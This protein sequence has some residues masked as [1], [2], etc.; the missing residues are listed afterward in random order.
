M[1]MQP[2]EDP[3]KAAFLQRVRE[4]LG[5]ADPLSATPDY[6]SLKTSLQRHEEKVRTIQAKNAARRPR[7]LTMLAENAT[8]AGWQV[9][10]VE[11]HED[12]AGL[13][14]D[15]A[16]RAGAKKVVRSAEDI[17]RTV[18]LDGALRRKRINWTVLTSG[19]NRQRSQLKDIAFESD[20]GVCGVA[21]AVAETAS[22]A[23][24]PHKG[25]ARL[26]SLAPP[27]LV[28]LV[29]ADQ[30]VEN[31]DDFFALMRLQYMQPRGKAP[32]YF[33]FISGPSKTA[34]IEMVLTTGVH[35]PGKIHMVLMS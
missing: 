5:Y 6:P 9:H 18:D 20:L 25:L 11:T 10:N 29:E 19:R 12:A 33:N 16:A 22:C 21:Y 14:G 4:A 7:L 3:N 24:V 30:V 31:L 8:K 23:I 27:E 1:T 34:D 2:Q 17:F 15:I 35:G 13:V 26:T 28:L 32:T